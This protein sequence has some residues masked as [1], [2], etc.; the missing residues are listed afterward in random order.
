MVVK[1]FFTILGAAITIFVLIV[2]GTQIVSCVQDKIKSYETTIANT[3][4]DC[5]VKFET[6]EYNRTKTT[7]Y[8]KVFIKNIGRAT[9]TEFYILAQFVDG[10]GKELWGSGNRMGYIEGRCPEWTESFALTD[11]DGNT[12]GK[13]TS[14][15]KTGQQAIIG[16][17]CVTVDNEQVDGLCLGV[18]TTQINQ[19]DGGTQ[20]DKKFNFR[21]TGTY[22]DA[23]TTALPVA[24]LPSRTKQAI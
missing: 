2:V 15:L 4:L 22:T 14:E 9:V 20:L 3:T 13:K 7:V 8:A 10:N 5:T 16:Q 19:N 12:T 23:A 1:A 6:R 21:G 11:D 18:K 17:I 24:L